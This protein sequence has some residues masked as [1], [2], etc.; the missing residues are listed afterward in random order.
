MS[1]KTITEGEV[2][3]EHLSEVNPLAHWAYLGGV[4]G[5]AIVLMLL[6]MALLGAGVR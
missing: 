1:E 6:F 2:R 5:G 3:E 4:L